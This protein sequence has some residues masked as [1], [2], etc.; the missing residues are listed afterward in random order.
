M[1]SRKKLNLHMNYQLL[2]ANMTERSICYYI[3]SHSEWFKE[4]FPPC[5]AMYLHRRDAVLNQLARVSGVKIRPVCT[6]GY[7]TYHV[8]CTPEGRKNI[9]RV[10][11][12]YSYFD[13]AN[14]RD[15]Q[16]CYFEEPQKPLW[17]YSCNLID[18]VMA[19]PSITLEI[20]SP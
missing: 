17:T 20:G 3:A 16:F 18:M 6:E 2:L 10:V 9:V 8:K 1:P 5:K 7:M 11:H 12:I 4:K 14:L 15:K 19:E 13:D